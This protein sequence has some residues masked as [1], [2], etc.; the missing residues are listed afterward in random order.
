[1]KYVMIE[2]NRQKSEAKFWRRLIDF[3]LD[4]SVNLLCAEGSSKFKETLDEVASKSKG[5]DD[6]LI[7]L[8]ST[9]NAMHFDTDMKHISDW[10]YHNPEKASRLCL[11]YP[12]EY[13]FEDCILLFQ[14]FLE[15]QY[16]DLNAIDRESLQAYKEYISID[17]FKKHTVI[18]DYL[19][20][21]DS[22]LKQ[23]C[24][25]YISKS[26]WSTCSFE[27][28]AGK[29]VMQL[30]RRTSR[31][32]DFRID[33]GAFGKCWY[34]DCRESDDLCELSKLNRDIMA[35]E[36][37]IKNRLTLLFEQNKC[38]LWEGSKALS[39][40]GSSFLK[41]EEKLH[42]IAVHSN[43]LNDILENNSWLFPDCIPDTTCNFPGL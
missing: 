39:F 19:N 34:C 1:M 7:C 12:E 28:L 15:W 27:V 24:E 13:C 25:K 11:H 35:A 10:I 23:W 16:P 5:R 43:I 4:P 18:K 38:G 14:Y 3:V 42:L 33:K 9:A 30:T 8:D 41:G 32:P 2:G 21:N 37:M 40:T 6:V 22:A 26:K 17:H 31:G 36:R 20:Q 29:L